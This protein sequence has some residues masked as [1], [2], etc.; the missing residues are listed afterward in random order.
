MER[1]DLHNCEDDVGLVT[2]EGN[3]TGVIITTIDKV[4]VM[5]E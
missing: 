1:W 5:Y 4:S 2:M 3:D